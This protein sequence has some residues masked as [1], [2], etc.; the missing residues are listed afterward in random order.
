MEPHAPHAKLDYR[1]IV[2]N[3][4]AI[5]FIAGTGEYG[6]WHYVNDWIEPILGFTAEEWLSDSTIWSRQLHPDDRAKT[7]AGEALEL[8][9]ALEQAPGVD[10]QEAATFFV[11]YRMLHKD[12]HVVWIRDSSVLVP[13][14]DGELL[15]HGVLLDISDQKLIEAE[16][17]RQSA[18]QAAVAQLG[19]HA[20]ERIPIQDLL[21][22]ACDAATRVLDIETALVIQVEDDQSTMEIRAFSSSLPQ[23]PLLHHVGIDP[24]SQLGTTLRIGRP[25]AVDDWQTEEHLTR[26]PGQIILDVR[27]GICARIEGPERPWGCFI[28]NSTRQRHYSAPDISFIQSLANVLADAIERQ[29]SED[30][31]EHKSLHDP[32]TGLPN[33]TLFADRLE[34]AFERLRR[35]HNAVASI[36]FIDVDHFK[37]VNDTLGHQ[38]GDELLVAVAQR[39]REAVR[40]TDTVARRSGDEFVVLL[41]EIASERDAIGT[42]ERIAAG[43]TRPFVLGTA[44]HFVTASLGIALADGYMSP[45]EL[46]ENADAAMY[47]AKER[48]RARYELFDEDMRIRAMARMKIENDLNR[49]LD[50]G[51]LRVVYQPVVELHDESIGGVEALLRWDHPQ[52]GQIP[53]DEFIPVAEESGSIDRIGRWVIEETLRSASRWHQLRPD[54]R[55]LLVGINVS[56]HQLQSPRFADMLNEQIA[57]SGV[58]PHTVCLEFSE[59]VLL[60]DAE[61]VR[62]ALRAL[63]RLG[64]ALVLDD[65][66]T[67]ES[68]LSHL[69][70]LPLRTLK[71]DRTFIAKLGADNQDSQIAHAL[72]AVGTALSLRVLGEGAETPEQVMELRRLGCV[73]AQ[74]YLFSPPVPEGDI[75][76]MLKS[77]GRLLRT[78]S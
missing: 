8:Q 65:F 31:I 2:E 13:N 14:A 39:L 56:T 49:A 74:G 34:Q 21:A 27:S 58:P 68:S 37:Q 59:R 11:D 1:A 67:G 33:R 22:E 19:E 43:F 57:A 69:A 12:G 23:E 42:A 54:S 4:P 6:S 51:E 32:L 17:A 61:P 16:F 30:A 60:D 41:E 63:S 48:G 7:I 55:P 47:R 18:A 76:A 10:S 46:L 75:T 29:D 53:P 73:A 66:G 5:A 70:S 25:T 77:G 71:V 78:M 15:W 26:G 62:Q 20:L 28:V 24:D 40:P 64:V 9:M 50:N 52:R 45:A 36:L 44:T 35:R 72:I 3:V 38:A